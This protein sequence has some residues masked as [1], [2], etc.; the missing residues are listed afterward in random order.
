MLYIDKQIFAVCLSWFF[1]IPRFV[2]L[3]IVSILNNNFFSED[4]KNSI[5]MIY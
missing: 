1:E 3:I 5:C 2:S 4:I